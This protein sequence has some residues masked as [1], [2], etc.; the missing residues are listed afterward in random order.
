VFNKKGIAVS[1]VDEPAVAMIPEVALVDGDTQTLFAP[2]QSSEI[3]VGQ[4]NAA[5]GTSER[6]GETD[7]VFHKTKSFIVRE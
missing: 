4:G 2:D 1:F 7:D 6:K 3:T 5:M